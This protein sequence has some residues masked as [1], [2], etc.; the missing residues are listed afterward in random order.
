MVPVIGAGAD[1]GSGAD[2]V[3]CEA[4]PHPEQA[5]KASPSARASERNERSIGGAMDTMGANAA[6]RTARAAFRS[7]LSENSAEALA[8]S[9]NLVVPAAGVQ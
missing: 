2:T 3:L 6:A 9:S 4:A 1:A 8:R 7:S 5:G